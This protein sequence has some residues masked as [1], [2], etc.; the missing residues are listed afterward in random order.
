MLA[1]HECLLIH[2]QTGLAVRT[3]DNDI[4][5]ATFKKIALQVGAS[6]YTNII[7]TLHYLATTHV[8]IYSL[9]GANMK[10]SQCYCL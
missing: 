2:L 10:P 3:T 1:N 7:R 9:V 8:H 4:K 5:D 6:I